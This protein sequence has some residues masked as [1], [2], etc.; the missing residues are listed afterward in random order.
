VEINQNLWA[1][2]TCPR[3]VLPT[4]ELLVVHGLSRC[5][6]KQNLWVAARSFPLNDLGL[7]SVPGM[8]HLLAEYREFWP[9]WVGLGAAVAAEIALVSRCISVKCARKCSDLA[10][11][12]GVHGGRAWGFW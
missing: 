9:K 8:S 4:A 1:A 3:A 12:F 7:Q 5:L 6:H 11:V 10:L 2:R